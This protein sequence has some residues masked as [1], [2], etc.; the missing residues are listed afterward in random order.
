[1]LFSQPVMNEIEE[2]YKK[3]QDILGAFMHETDEKINSLKNEAH[4]LGMKFLYGT[5]PL[6]DLGEDNIFEILLSVVE[7]AFFARENTP[8]GEKV[9][10]DIFLSDV[11]F[12]RVNSERLEISRKFFYDSVIDR[13]KDK[14]M[15]D[16]V[17]EINYYCFENATYKSTDRRTAPPST[18]LKS[19]Y[20]R[21]GEEATFT[22][23]VLRSV[24]IPARQ[25][26]TPRW[27]H[28][29]N[30]HAWVEAWCDGKWYY[31]GACEPEEILDRGWFTSAASRA[32]LLESRAFY[33]NKSL[34]PDVEY[35]LKGLSAS[36]NHTKRYANTKR[37]EITLTD[38]QNQPVKDAKIIVEIANH[39]E[40]SELNTIYTDDEGKAGITTGIGSVN[41]HIVTD[42][43]FMERLIHTEDENNVQITFVPERIQEGAQVFISDFDTFA[44]RDPGNK[45]QLLEKET[46]QRHKEKTGNALKIRQNKE[47]STL[48]KPQDLIQNTDCIA[49]KDLEDI[50]LKAKGNGK[51]IISFLHENPGVYAGKL[52]MTLNEKDYTDLESPVLKTHLDHALQY[53]DNFIE[54]VFVNYILCPRIHFETITDYRGFIED[55]FTEAQKRD[56]RE[57]P[58]TIWAYINRNIGYMEDE[59]FPNTNINPK[60][61]LKIKY[62]SPLAKKILFVAICRTLGIPARVAS[63]TIDIEYYSNGKF[64]SPVEAEIRDAKLK[65]HFE[66]GVNWAYSTNF[67]IGYL[68][69][70][71]YKTLVLK[72][73][74]ID[75]DCIAL[76][77]GSY[78]IITANRLPNGDVLGRKILF[79]L[80]KDKIKEIE[81]T[82]R[83]IAP[84]KMQNHVEI[85]DF[86][87]VSK[88][89]KEIGISTILSNKENILFWIEENSEPCQH[90]L[91]E[92]LENEKA[93]KDRGINLLFVFKDKAAEKDRLI[94]QV[95]E[96]LSIN[97]CYDFGFEMREPSARRTYVDPEKLP[98]II[99]TKD[100]LHSV[101]ALA[102]YNVGSADMILKVLG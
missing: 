19:G 48:S 32:M 62:A 43:G 84:E 51:S 28:C 3:R 12:P 82:L 15:Y 34:S 78:R 8:W 37:T 47:A 63:D 77:S 45:V 50:L 55:Y 18:L 79:N 49:F 17:V 52:L 100:K 11:L 25:V 73:T 67:S 16:A 27:A 38:E 10:L 29:D 21:C 70:G 41:L 6:S 101:F 91:N 44:P 68:E 5:L 71:I 75:A 61:A 53:K 74:E 36:L 14:S 4:R 59:E 20:G 42:K 13:I 93:F 95:M 65:L 96:R 66:A 99:V 85:G 88:E 1:M 56:F 81:L 83:P 90:I 31:L 92:L 60:G 35:I 22:V 57:E 98:L 80:E 102:G 72:N 30:N 58:K 39:G 26:Y 87:V 89:N 69:D 94:A 86:G 64:I 24:G 46:I 2:K 23:T 97:Y 33:H 76:K 54:D 7:G 9:P 40:F